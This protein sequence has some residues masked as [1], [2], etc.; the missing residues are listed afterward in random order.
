[1]ALLK[2]AGGRAKFG[3]M[4]TCPPPLNPH[5]HRIKCKLSPHAVDAREQ[6]AT[7]SCGQRR[8][9]RSDMQRTYRDTVAL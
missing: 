7:V 5:V 1:M 3:G 2:L 8:H 4:L 6:S 9:S